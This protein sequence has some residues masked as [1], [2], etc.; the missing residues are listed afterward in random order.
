MIVMFSIIYTVMFLSSLAPHIS[1]YFYTIYTSTTIYFPLVTCHL[2][3]MFM[4][5]VYNCTA[6]TLLMYGVLDRLLVVEFFCVYHGEIPTTAELLFT[7]R[8]VH[9]NDT[10]VRAFV[11]FV[12]LVL[13]PMWVWIYYRTVLKALSCVR[14]YE[15]AI[16]GSKF[17]AKSRINYFLH[18]IWRALNTI[19]TRGSKRLFPLR[20]VEQTLRSVNSYCYY[21]LLLLLLLLLSKSKRKRQKDTRMMND[22]DNR[23]A[24]VSRVGRIHPSLLEF[25]YEQSTFHAKK[26]AVITK[27][28]KVQSKIIFIG[29]WNFRWLLTSDSPAFDY[30]CSKIYGKFLC[31]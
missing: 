10:H 31:F 19:L 24:I 28:S 2:S 29:K 5:L 9:S 14:I 30:D 4:F 20:S 25:M 26:G 22:V 15:W 7:F 16:L 3:N 8:V 23:P 11:S 1:Y 12:N 13:C 17:Y 6:T 18:R 27:E 21:P